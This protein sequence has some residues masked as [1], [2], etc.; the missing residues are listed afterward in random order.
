MVKG[1]T[2]FLNILKHL[3]IQS[4]NLLVTIDVKSM[5]TNIPHTEGIAVITKMMEDTGL[6]T[7]HRMFICNLAH[8][9]LTKNY[10]I[11]NKQL[12]I[13]K[14]GA[15]MGTMMAPNYAIIFMHYLESNLLEITKRKLKIWLRFI[16]DIFMIWSHGLQELKQFMDR[17]NNY[18]PP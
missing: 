9:V 17:M 16:D 14:Q 4:T 15:A 1:T 11:F 12:N 8:Q 18:H 13:Q 7:L 3:E 6:D 5:Y 2:H 10:F